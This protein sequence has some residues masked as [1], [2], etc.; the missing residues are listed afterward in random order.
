[1]EFVAA[2]GKPQHK[3]FVGNLNGWLRDEYPEKS[4]NLTMGTAQTF[5]ATA[6]GGERRLKEFAVNVGRYVTGLTLETA[7]IAQGRRSVIFALKRAQRQLAADDF[8]ALEEK[9]GFETSSR[10]FLRDVFFHPP[11]RR[12]SPACWP[13]R[14]R[15][16][17]GV[18]VPP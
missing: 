1:M 12:S 6:F 3:A 9:N 14:N 8:Q 4:A 15:S 2:P 11:Q 16:F 10:N 17:F 13:N 5:F 18:L 7:S